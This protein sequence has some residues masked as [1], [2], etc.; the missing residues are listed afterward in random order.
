MCNAQQSFLAAMQEIYGSLEFIPEAD[1]RIHRFDVPED[2]RGRRN[3]WYVLH[4][5]GIAA[6]AFGSWK[7]GDA[8]T[9]S[10]HAPSSHQEIQRL[11]QKITQVRR[12]REAEQRLRQQEVAIY[13]KRLWHNATPADPD[14]PYLVAKNCHPHG[15]RQKG[16]QILVPLGRDKELLNVQRITPDGKKRF[17]SGGVIKRCYSTLGVVDAGK[18]PLYICEGWATGATLHEYTG[19]AVACAMNAGNLLAVGNH[20]RQRFPD[21]KLIVAGD[22]DRLTTGNPGRTA[23]INTAATLGCE[24]VMPAWPNDAPLNLTDFNDLAAWREGQI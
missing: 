11:R 9:W 22:D 20:L 17:L 18:H 23:A 12:Q 5:D 16:D 21:V 4:A 8:H 7:R 3:G 14:H 6:G 1:G 19:A 15:L 10:S 24:F 2:K 13:A